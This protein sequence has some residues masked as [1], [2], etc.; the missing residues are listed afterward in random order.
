MSSSSRWCSILKLVI[1][2]VVVVF[3][4]IFLSIAT[5]E[6]LQ[7]GPGAGTLTLRANS[8][9]FGHF[10]VSASKRLVVSWNAELV[11]VNHKPHLHV[12]IPPFNSFLIYDGIPISCGFM[13]ETL[14]IGTKQEKAFKIHGHSLG[15]EWGR[16]FMLSPYAM[17]L[18]TDIEQ[19]KKVNMGMEMSVG[20]YYKHGYWGWDVMMKPYC[21][22][23][24]IELTSAR[25]QGRLVSVGSKTCKVPQP[26]WYH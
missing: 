21:D 20:A 18:T 16:L 26:L 11:F 9:T 15:C 14:H 25:G 17:N 10:Y 6:T 3:A 19:N 2:L 13:N 8:I 22:D 7:F 12:T 23:L 24:S 4:T 1:Y 5:Y